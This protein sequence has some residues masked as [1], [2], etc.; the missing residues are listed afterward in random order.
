MLPRLADVLA[1]GHRHEPPST[2]RVAVEHLLPLDSI[3]YHEGVGVEFLPISVKITLS[4]TFGWHTLRP[5]VG[6]LSAIH[7]G[8]WP[9]EISS[10]HHLPITNF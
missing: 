7:S 9:V 2:C 1:S 4:V 10:I 8:A 6:N 5:V 3:T